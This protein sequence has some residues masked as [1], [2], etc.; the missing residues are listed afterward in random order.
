MHSSHFTKLSLESRKLRK[1]GREQIEAHTKYCM[2]IARKSKKDVQR[3]DSPETASYSCSLASM[4]IGET[5]YG[6]G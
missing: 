3:R 5:D 6:F 4:N 1:G 2:K